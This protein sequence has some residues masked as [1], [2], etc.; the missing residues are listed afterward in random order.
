MRTF[1]QT[2]NAGLELAKQFKETKNYSSSVVNIDWAC[3]RKAAKRLLKQEQGVITPTL[4][5]P[6]ADAIYELL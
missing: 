6:V 2:V 1:S 3:A 4:W 5:R